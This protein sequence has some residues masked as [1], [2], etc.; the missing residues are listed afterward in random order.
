MPLAQLNGPLDEPLLSVGDREGPLLRHAGGHGRRGRTRLGPGGDG[1]QLDR[2]VRSV[3]G[4][5]FPRWQAAD[6]GVA[7]PSDLSPTLAR[8]LD[9]FSRADAR[10]RGVA[11][12][13][14]ARCLMP[15]KHLRIITKSA[16]STK[17]PNRMVGLVHQ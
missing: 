16:N 7:A 17:R 6:G 9:Y 2:R 4:D 14:S 10:S 3:P 8:E 11:A 15:S 1:R 13:R 12:R 5:H